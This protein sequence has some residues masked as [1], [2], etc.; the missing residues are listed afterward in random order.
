MPTQQ[1]IYLL[2]QLVDYHLWFVRCYESNTLSVIDTNGIKLHANTDSTWLVCCEVDIFRSML[3]NKA[4][5][6]SNTFKYDP[7]RVITL[8]RI[9]TFTSG[10]QHWHYTIAPRNSLTE[11]LWFWI[12]DDILQRQNCRWFSSWHNINMLRY[13]TDSTL[14]SLK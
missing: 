13:C 1:H 9:I 5:D 7:W 3:M 8:K 2:T 12:R 6:V 11:C 14:S 4:R 10:T